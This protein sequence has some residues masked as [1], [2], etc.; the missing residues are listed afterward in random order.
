MFAECK[1]CLEKEKCPASSMAS[2]S[3]SVARIIAAA[4]QRKGQKG[5]GE[6]DDDK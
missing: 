2:L 3:S 5:G 4:V 6:G 1:N